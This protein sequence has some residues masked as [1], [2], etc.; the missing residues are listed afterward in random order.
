ML[1]LLYVTADLESCKYVS[2]C[3]YNR[4]QSQAT[5]NQSVQGVIFG[6]HQN[7]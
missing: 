6:T 7:C 1:F 4:R 5:S 3:V 2:V